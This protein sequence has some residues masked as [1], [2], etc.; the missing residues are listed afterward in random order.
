[1]LK[2]WPSTPLD[3]IIL[4]FFSCCQYLTSILCFPQQSWKDWGA[5]WWPPSGEY[6]ILPLRHSSCSIMYDM[7]CWVSNDSQTP[8]SK[9]GL[10]SVEFLCNVLSWLYL[11]YFFFQH[12]LVLQF[13]LF[14]EILIET[15]SWLVD[16]GQLVMISDESLK[17][18]SKCLLAPASQIWIFDAF[19]WH[20]WQ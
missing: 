5:E 11:L 12:L 6:D 4:C 18:N 19:P 1:M 15:S 20:V 3:C 2:V 17:Q 14:E 9:S 8:A 7:N 13:Y 16:N 10:S